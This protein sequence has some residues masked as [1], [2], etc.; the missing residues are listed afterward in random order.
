MYKRQDYILVK[1]SRSMNGEKIL[2]EFF[3]KHAWNW[4]TYSVQIK[5][6]ER[7]NPVSTKGMVCEMDIS[8]IFVCLAASFAVSAF[9]GKLL[10]PFLTKLHFGQNIL[11]KDGPSWHASKQGTPT[12]GGFCFIISTVITSLI[13]AFPYYS[14]GLDAATPVS[15]THLFWL[16][17]ILTIYLYF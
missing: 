6:S 17:V 15:Y 2:S 7:L 12:M 5:I 8:L 16:W 10:I 14:K 4:K 1:S 11:V 13:F 3:D 9:T